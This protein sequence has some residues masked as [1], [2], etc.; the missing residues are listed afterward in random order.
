[1]NSGH[2]V[3]FNGASPEDCGPGKLGMSGVKERFRLNLGDPFIHIPDMA[4]HK[5]AAVIDDVK[6]TVR[7]VEMVYNDWQTIDEVC[8]DG[9]FE[10]VANDLELKVLTLAKQL[11]GTANETAGSPK[12]PPDGQ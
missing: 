11:Y 8:G 9:S 10:A 6:I 2:I 4:V 3:A 1:M 12:L 5:V 7:T